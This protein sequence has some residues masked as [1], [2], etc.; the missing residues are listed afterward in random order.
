MDFTTVVAVDEPHLA[1]L[2]LVW[3]TWRR[4]RP[5]I[6]DNP[7]LLICD[8]TVSLDRWKRH[9]RFIDHPNARFV[10]WKMPHV[11]QREKML[12]AF[13]HCVARHVST[14]WHLKLD[15]DTVAVEKGSWLQPAW[16]LPDEAGRRPVF[17]S[18][19]WG[20]TKPAKAIDI[21]E[22]WGDS[23]PELRGYPRLNLRPAIGSDRVRSPRI[24]SWCFLGDTEWV[25]GVSAYASGRLPFPSHDTYLWYCAARS[26]RFFRRVRM[27]KLG[28]RH[29]HRRA[30]LEMA[31]R[32]SCA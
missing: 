29:I 32:S 22:A 27:N 1:E 9:V 23:L 2:K 6:L 28:W 24:T 8:G 13:V 16:L 17:I 7:L 5:E 15:T 31:C 10:L 11:S 21:L 25:R 20:Y 3:P 30:F 4:F 26:G 12:T 18:H 14:P 19:A